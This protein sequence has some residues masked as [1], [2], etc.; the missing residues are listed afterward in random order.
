MSDGPDSHSGELE[1]LDAGKYVL[2]TTYRRDGRTV[3][4]PVWKVRDGDALGVWT[5]AGSGKVKRIRNRGDVLL[6][7]CDVRGRPTGPEVRG[8]AELLDDEGNR[9]YRRLIARRYRLTG[10]LVL[11][12]SRLRHGVRGTVGIRITVAE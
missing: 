7:P 12:G 6:A 8:H 10:P 5:N 9:R 11:L 4:T 2:V 1:R 3:P